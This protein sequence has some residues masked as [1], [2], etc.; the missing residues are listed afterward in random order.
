MTLSLYNNKLSG[1]IPPQLGTCSNLVEL[2]LDGN[3]LSGTFP[4]ALAYLKNLSSIFLGTN[5]PFLNS[6]DAISNVFGD[7]DISGSVPLAIFKNMNLKSFDVSGNNLTGDITPALEELSKHPNIEWISIEANSFTGILSPSI[8]NAI[9]LRNLNLGGQNGRGLDGPIPNEVTKLVNL[10]F[11]ELSSNNLTGEIP[12]EIGTRMTSLT[13]LGLAINKLNGNIPSTLG[14]LVNLKSI[15]LQDNNLTG[16]I[17][18]SLTSINNL[19]NLNFG[20]NIHLT[21]PIP[22]DLPKL[23]A[24]EAI[25]LSNTSMSGPI[26][27][28]LGR[29]MPNLTTIDI[30]D[31]F[32]Q[33][34][35]PVG[36]C[37]GNHLKHI[38]G[39]GNQL[40]G[41]I[42]SSLSSCKSLIRVRLEDNKFTSIPDGFGSD[43]SLV[44]LG[45]SRNKLTGQL[46]KAL[47]T[48]S[49]L[50]NL[51]LSENELTGD[52]SILEFSQLAK[53]LSVLN[54]AKNKITGK[55]PKSMGM[56][57]LL[58]LIDL[59]YNSLTEAVP[60]ELANLSSLQKL[61]LQ[62]NNL[63][64]LDPSMYS[65][66]AT[67][68]LHLNLAENSWNAPIATETGSL[69]VLQNLNLSHGGLTGS[70]P[71]QLGKLAQLETLDL[72][73]NNLTGEVPHELGEL[74]KS[75]TIVNISHN[76]LTGSLPP[77][78]LPL[79]ISNPDCFTGNPDLCLEY[80][81]S[82][83]QCITISLVT[84][85][86]LSPKIIV[87]T[88][89]GGALTISTIVAFLFYW[90]GRT[91]IPNKKSA[92]ELDNIIV[93]NLTN[94]PLPFTFE[95]IMTATEN[96]NDAYIIGRGGHGVVYKVTSASCSTTIAVKKI[97]SDLDI[98]KAALVQKSFWSEIETVGNTKHRNLVRLLGFMKWEKVGLLLYEY[99][100]NGDL[101]S[102]LH[103]REVVEGVE[104]VG[105]SW[106]ER[107]RV[108]RGVACGLA[109][110]HHDYDPPIVH[111]DVKSSNVLLDDDFE[112][113]ISDFG[114]A[115]VLLASIVEPWLSST[116][117]LGTY[118]YIAPGGF[119][120][121][122]IILFFVLG[123][124]LER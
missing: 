94:S 86:K 18:A 13:Y 106:M 110:L 20:L 47:G 123:L 81:T 73:H 91:K 7:N 36:L 30:S 109:Y 90:F 102:A 21:G 2:W 121:I 50:T 60:L 19:Q 112:P 82:T 88:T 77:A 98:A 107:L 119:Y 74:M 72:S 53:N 40:E 95:E 85:T 116:N 59:S 17:P 54:L 43:S 118:G 115:K 69:T 22:T 80:N 66:W 3:M 42:P 9:A 49:E 71:S 93:K 41:A 39:L 6:L 5:P 58:F 70:I 29:F 1:E 51:D 97:E 83:K 24:L 34:T 104:R 103:G 32:F 111:R 38:I 114:L 4:E 57:K 46:P 113:R 44:Y 23:T 55:I 64:G 28:D 25:L 87:A 96:L 122:F 120:V 11:F 31:S 75:L 101:H 63:T 99:V 8:G 12:P 84:K 108:A 62:G 48:N 117:V 14:N 26:P 45:L 100:S 68:L 65:S 37:Q 67:S 89:L 33:G 92:P 105:L 79:L 27:E 78:W 10:D 35:L 124:C 61:H 52:I 16:E 76:R 15:Y 56:C